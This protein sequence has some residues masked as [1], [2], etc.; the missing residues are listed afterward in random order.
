MVI[1]ARQSWKHLQ[2]ERGNRVAQ[3]NRDLIDSAVGSVSSTR[4]NPP[5]LLIRSQINDCNWAGLLTTSVLRSEDAQQK[6]DQIHFIG[7]RSAEAG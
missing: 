5:T 1:I 6:M 7:C 4:G 3:R 2:Q